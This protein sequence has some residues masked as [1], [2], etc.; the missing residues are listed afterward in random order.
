MSKI[1]STIFI[2]ILIILFCIFGEYYRWIFI[3]TFYMI[4]FAMTLLL[5]PFLFQEK[6][7]PKEGKN[8]KHEMTGIIFFMILIFLAVI[9]YREAQMAIIDYVFATKPKQEICGVFERK[10][11][12]GSGKSSSIYHVVYNHKTHQSFAFAP[13]K[14]YDFY[15]LGDKIC[16]KYAI[17]ERWQSRSYI[18]SVTKDFK[19]DKT[20][21]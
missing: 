2:Y 16:V 19:N 4:L 18:Y 11:T 8:K 1:I 21:Y 13:V 15:Q 12:R 5:A 3:V 14:K 20:I 7:T 17:D 10:E 9:L 6:D